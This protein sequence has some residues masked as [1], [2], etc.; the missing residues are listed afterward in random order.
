MREN[1]NIEPFNF[2]VQ[3]QFGHSQLSSLK[4]QIVPSSLIF[5]DSI[6]FVRIVT[7]SSWEEKRTRTLK[8][9]LRTTLRKMFPYAKPVPLRSKDK[10]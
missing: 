3:P 2:E 4:I 10:F 6:F 5:A 7:A 1:A 8:A 9:S